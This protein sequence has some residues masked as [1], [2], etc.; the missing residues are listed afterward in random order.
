[1]RR[2]IPWW[3]AALV[4]VGEGETHDFGE[5]NGRRGG[6]PTLVGVQAKCCKILVVSAAGQATWM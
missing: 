3:K 1:M 4:V 2:D 6:R 5:G